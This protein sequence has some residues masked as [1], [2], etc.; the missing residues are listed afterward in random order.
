MIENAERRGDAGAARTDDPLVTVVIGTKE[1]PEDIRRAIPSVLRSDYT[2]FEFLIIDQS[3]DDQT[4]E[5]VEGFAKDDSRIN[6]VR[7]PRQGLARAQNLAMRLATTEIIAI[8]DD[9]CEVDIGWLSSIVRAFQEDPELGLLFG[10]VTPEEGYE[11]EGFIVGYHIKKRRRLRGRMAKRLDGGISASMAVRRPVWQAVQGMD[12]VLGPGSYFP[13]CEDGDFAYRVLKAGYPMLHLPEA[14][15]LHY[16][17]RE[18]SGGSQ[19]TR[20]TYLSIA[21]AY[22]K[23][24]R[25]GDLFALYLLGDQIAAAMGNLVKRIVTWRRP[26]GFR[27]LT[28]IFV[29]IYRSFERSVDRKVWKYH[30]DSN[31]LDTG[32][33]RAGNGRSL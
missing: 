29:G 20:R 21:A 5:I 6:Y 19:L 9:D 14:R 31:G 22:F 2:N 3:P 1:R 12:E 24:V 13:N 30:G 8:T 27:R 16:G 25:C 26:F 10:E 11:D 23:H 17:L 28:Y 4:R 33:Q 18:W 7:D 32:S 15:V